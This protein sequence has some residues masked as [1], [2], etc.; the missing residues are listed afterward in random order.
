MRSAEAKCPIVIV[1]AAADEPINCASGV[2]VDF[3]YVKALPTKGEAVETRDLPAGRAAAL[4][5][6]DDE[7]I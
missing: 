7:M 5:T 1:N 2:V 3:E 4:G 6:G